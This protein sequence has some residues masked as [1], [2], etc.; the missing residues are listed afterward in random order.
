MPDT[1]NPA[2]ESF[3]ASGKQFD[4]SFV[5]PLKGAVSRLLSAEGRRRGGGGGV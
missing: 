3:V 2:T 4:E 5:L 1:I